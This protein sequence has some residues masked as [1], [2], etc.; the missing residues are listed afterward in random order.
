MCAVRV[1]CVMGNEWKRLVSPRAL[2]GVVGALLGI[3]VMTSPV[4]AQDDAVPEESLDLSQVAAMMGGR[5]GGAARSNDNLRP[6][7]DVAEGFEPVISQD[8]AFYSVWINRKTNQMLAELPRGY[9]RQ[10]H[11]FAMTVS[12][13]EIFA[14]LQAADMYTQWKRINDRMALVLPQISVRST[15][16]QESKDSVEMIFTDRVL[17]DVPVLSIGPSGQPVIDL[18]DLLVGNAGSF[19]AGSSRGLN[20]SLTTIKSVKVFPE[21]IEVEIEGPVAGGVM[22]SFHYSI[23]L[24]RGTPGFKPREADPRVGYF[25]TSYR[26]LGKFTRDETNQRYINRWHLEKADPKLKLSPPK[27]PIV[28]YVEHTVPIRYRRWVREGIEQWND[29]FRKVGI[30][31]AIEVRFQDKSSGAHMDKDPE[32]VRYNFIRWISNDVATA[33][34]PS[35]VNPMTGEIL[36]ADV[37]LT[38]GWIRV[39]TYRWD[40]LLG[41]LAVE[42][43]SPQ[44][45]AWLERNPRWDPRLRLASPERRD[46]ILIERQAR[47]VTRY[48]G[49]A[50]DTADPTLLGDNEFD[51]LLRT[52]QVSG[53]CRAASGKALD[54]AMMRMYLAAFDTAAAI[55]ETVA[56]RDEDKPK[57]DPE[58]IEMIRK[59]LEENPA[60]RAMVPADVLAMLEEPAA[61]EQAEEP[62]EEPKGEEKPK[63]PKQDPGELIDG[64]PEWFVG[65]ML[66]ELV[67]HEVG[68]TLGLR[69]NFKGSSAYDLETI[70]SDEFKGKKPWSTSVMDYNGINI[71]MPGYGAE[72]GDFSVIDIGPYDYWAIEFGYGNDPKK[73]LE[74]VAEPELQYGTDEDTWGPDPT[75]RRYDLGKDPLVWAENQMAFVRH[76]RE[77]LLT[78]FVEDGD[79]WAKARRGYRITLGTQTQ[80]L[81]MAANWVGSAYV[82]RDKKGDPNGRVPIDPVT[83]D[84]QR[85]ALS[86]VIENSFKD[87]AFGITP[88][89][90]RH[91]TVDK[92]FDDAGYMDA[93]A[94]ATIPIHDQVMGIQASAMSMILNPGT[95][96]RVYDLELYSPADQDVLTLA[97]VMNT[98]R[99]AV[100]SELDTE[101]S[102]KFTDRKPM[103]SSL[104]R[105]LQREHVERLID[106]SMNP[107]GFSAVDMPVRTLAV[108][109]LRDLHGRIEKRM[110]NAGQLDSYTSAHLG[111]IA[112][113]IE[114]ALDAAYIYNTD[115]IGGGG[116]P[117]FLFGRDAED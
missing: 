97:E 63:A 72:Q 28:Y 18:D 11:F 92:W 34:G 107:S 6:F 65:P 56:A 105:N 42:G 3:G 84:Q 2:T 14:G 87:E 81:S 71:R 64:V 67:A 24:I 73:T 46:Q 45:L 22:K 115:D 111:E 93:L 5:G 13:G 85:K 29:A 112:V 36:D 89:L 70:N 60:L 10:N 102:Q 25:T 4:L 15:G 76:L 101:A 100:W 96:Q 31:G 21:N 113:R 108:A 95:L 104:R 88:E 20:R 69:H 98:I 77:R 68:H 51:G 110:G 61:E 41:D 75:A 79:S 23:S 12:G 74:R 38:D 114:K 17:L 90:L 106:L 43:M 9:E 57:L 80:M 82:Y 83:A 32:D 26:D 53:M 44:T 35:R 48:G 33:I 62:K 8:G 40:E 99:D 30:D 59:Q 109:Q 91:T 49:H 94:D 27:Q 66:A 47:G 19:F 7:K 86:F 117:M 37:V 54:L 55:E 116:F 16:D 1:E 50:L 78:D 52:S 39:F 58:T 103:I